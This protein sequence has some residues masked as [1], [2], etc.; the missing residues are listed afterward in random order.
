MAAE[1][2]RHRHRGRHRRRY[3]RVQRA[4]WMANKEEWRELAVVGM[5]CGTPASPH[6]SLPRLAGARMLLLPAWRVKD[7]GGGVLTRLIAVSV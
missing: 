6:G 5:L 7:G 4:G 2:Y 3:R 1:R